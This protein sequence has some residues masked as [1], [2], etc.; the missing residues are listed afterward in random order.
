MCETNK[1]IQRASFALSLVLKR[2]V[3][4]SCVLAFKLSILR[5]RLKNK[6]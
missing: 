2:A 5:Y 3:L 4:L 1:L 6:I